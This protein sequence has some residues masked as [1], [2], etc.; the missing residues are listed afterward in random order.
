ML[1][2]D[3]PSRALA[4]I[5]EVYD[6][7]G[8]AAVGR[9]NEFEGLRRYGIRFA[10]LKGFA[11][12]REDVTGKSLAIEY[13]RWLGTAFSESQKPMEVELLVAEVGD[14]I[15][16][17]Q[18]YRITFDGSLTDA[19]G[20]LALGGSA[21]ALNA[22]LDLEWDVAASW[23]SG[24]QTA[25]RLLGRTQMVDLEVALL[26]RSTSGRVFRRIAPAEYQDLPLQLSGQ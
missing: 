25:A 12:G 6:R 8:F 4:K 10:D 24:L 14:V 13:A 1:V 11:Y 17:D 3:N 2:A 5:S 20:A 19:V 9:Y 26:E 15:A 23:Q 16:A 21:D 7:I 22:A 18:L